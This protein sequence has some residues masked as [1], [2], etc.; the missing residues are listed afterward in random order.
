MSKKQKKN[1][2]NPECNLQDLKWL[3]YIENSNMMSKLSIG[4][5]KIHVYDSLRMVI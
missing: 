5:K 2:K 4:I 1:K 3:I